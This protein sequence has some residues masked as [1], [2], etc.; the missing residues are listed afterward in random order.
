MFE[1]CTSLKRLIF[2]KI[3][4]NQ[5]FNAEY[6]FFG[7][8]QLEYIHMGEIFNNYQYYFDYMFYNCKSLTFLNISHLYMHCEMLEHI[9]IGVNLP[10]RLIIPEEINQLYR[11]AISGLNIID[12]EENEKRVFRFNY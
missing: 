6:M 1:N 10:I 12:D 5:Y 3:T 2:P 9:F 7:C 11:I 4:A 8:I